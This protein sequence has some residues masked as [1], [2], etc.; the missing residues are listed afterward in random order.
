MTILPLLGLILPAFVNA[1]EM[2][3]SQ[4]PKSGTEKKEAVTEAAKAGIEVLL[5]ASKGGQKHTWE[6][7]APKVSEMID[8]TASLLFPSQSSRVEETKT[9][10]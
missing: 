8:D 1:A 2:L 3:F 10:E 4:R 6:R 9:A 7:I 5:A